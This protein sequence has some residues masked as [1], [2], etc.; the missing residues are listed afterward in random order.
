MKLFHNFCRRDTD[1]ANKQLR[2]L[3]DDDVDEIVKL[4]FGVVVL[5]TKINDKGTGPLGGLTF[6]LRAPPPICGI[7]RSTPKGASLSSSWLFSSSIPCRSIFGLYVNPP[8]TPI[9]P[10]RT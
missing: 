5:W 8:M 3:L 9:P 7:A 4:A 1:G 2:F 10:V 6:V